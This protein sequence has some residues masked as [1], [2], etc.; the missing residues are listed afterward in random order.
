MTSQP[1]ALGACEGLIDRGLEDLKDDEIAWMLPPTA[2][3]RVAGGIDIAVWQRGL[4][5]GD[6][7]RLDGILDTVIVA[8]VQPQTL[9]G[10]QLLKCLGSL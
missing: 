5:L 3:G 10:L 4:Q 7:L 6:N 9:K 2:E 1:L 8:V